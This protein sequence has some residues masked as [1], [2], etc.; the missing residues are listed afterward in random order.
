[1]KKVLFLIA[2]AMMAATSW[3]SITVTGVVTSQADGEPVIGASV[4]EK[5]TTNGTITDFDGNFT[6]TVKDKATLVVSYV[7]MTTQ[8][9]KV[10]GPK[11]DVVLSDDAIAMEEVVVTAMG[12]V[13]EKKRLNFA[14]QNVNSEDITAGKSANF[15]NALQGKV[16]GVNVTNG[17]G[18]PN[19]GTN[20]VIRGVT[21]ISSTQEN[22]PLIVLDGMPLTG[23]ASDI[24]PNDIESITV[25]K[26]AAA[27]ALYGSQAAKGVLMITTKAASA[28]KVKASVNAS[29]QFDTPA[30]LM[31]VQQKYLPGSQGFYR[32][33]TNN[34]WGPLADETDVLYSNLRNYF[35]DY[36]FYHKYDLNVSG[37]T[38][39]FQAMASASY[40]KADGIVVN[41]YRQK[42][43][44]LIKATFSPNK[45]ITM[46][47]MSNVIHNDYRS[48]GGISTAFNWPIN[49]DITNY[50][51]ENGNIR[52]LYYTNPKTGSPF[53]P[54]YSRYYDQGVNKNT[55]SLLQ[56]HITVKPV[57]GLE[58]TAR[59]GLDQN[60]YYYDGYSIPRW[61]RTQTL[62]DSVQDT[63]AYIDGT[64]GSILT[65]KD[66]NNILNTSSLGEY[67]Y[68]TSESR[69]ITASF[70]AT[71]H[72]DLPHDFGFDALVGM[73]LQDRYSISSKA[74]GRDFIIPGVY[75]LLNVN[76]HN[77]PGETGD[78]NVGHNH[79]RLV[80]VY[81]ELRADYKGLATLSVTSRWDWSSALY[82]EYC[83]YWYPSI[84]AGLIFSELIPGLN[85][86][87]NNW[88]SYGKLRGNY[89]MVGTDCPPYLM[90]RR[91]TQFTTLPDPGYSTYASLTRGFEIKPEIT[92][93][94]EIGADL[95]FFNN[96][97]RLDVAYYST[98]TANQIV[99]V[100]VSLASGDVLQTRN[101]GTVKNH[102]FEATLEQDIIKRNGWLWT[103][104]LNIGL[105]R[106][107]VVSLPDGMEEIE[108]SQFGDIFP[109][110]YLGGSTTA[111]SGKDY[112]R[113][114]DGQIICDDN[115]YPQI[116][117]RKSLLIGNREPKCMLGLNTSVSYKGWSLGLLLDGRV[118]GDVANVTARSL[119][120]NGMHP[121]IEQYRGRQVVWDGV[122]E[123]KDDAGN[124]TGEYVKNTKPIVLDSQ[125]I[126]NYYYEVSSNFIEDGSYLRLGYVALSYDFKDLLKNVKGLDDIKLTFTGNNLFLLT[127]Y[128]GS[129]PQISADTSGYGVGGNGIDSYAVPQTRS[130]NISLQVNF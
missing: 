74:A 53:S 64:T 48:A 118:G 7:G 80:G 128:T 22:N 114:E 25:L 70:L 13:Q 68:S 59:V 129:D 100:R 30:N 76:N 19:S 89:A 113:T 112:L 119:W 94:W 84:T 27:S 126:G 55:R 26:G 81:G 85:E 123:V 86:T 71:Y 8:E 49:D 57:K 5:G 105:N 90:N 109:T 98:Q 92:T 31:R 20:I 95:R 9:I 78:S 44:A 36:G 32:E 35:K 83:P 101:E 38:E 42:V 39:K 122:V 23:G 43:S 87:K 97:T 127:R 77:G 93:S 65:N 61:S 52:F 46:G 2:C 88:F 3:A 120:S 75:S 34:G 33:Q 72:I 117:P 40:S 96:R 111:I 56:G 54:L 47:L 6:L 58:L 50:A 60:N 51:D 41:D 115:G 110:A 12:V 108:G 116:N 14:V 121:G 99:T 16:A 107:V 18:S 11:H 15:L 28:G 102:G 106:G 45:Y 73:D 63:E 130:Y 62:D 67:S 17:G 29:W 24:N 66:L 21:S 124:G 10:T 4:L 79:K 103:A 91:F 37:G 69:Y 104:G 1:M 82:Q 125:T